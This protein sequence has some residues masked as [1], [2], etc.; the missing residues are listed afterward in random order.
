M[1]RSLY[2][3]LE[4]DRSLVPAATME[5]AILEVLTIPD[6]YSDA[7]VQSIAESVLSSGAIKSPARS[8]AQGGPVRITWAALIEKGIAGGVLEEQEA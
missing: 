7:A 4:P 6:D 8:G 1:N 2:F 3:S 5:S